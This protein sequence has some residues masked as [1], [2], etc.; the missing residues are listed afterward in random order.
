MKPHIRRK[1]AGGYVSLIAV[2]TMSLFMLSLMLFA[3]K[4][5]ISAQGIQG[6]IQSQTDYREKEETILRS[7]VAIAPNRAIRAMQSGSD[8]SSATRDPLRWQNIFSEA[9]DQSNARQSVSPQLL[10][11]MNI[12]ESFSA[13]SGDSSLG[14]LSRIFLPTAGNTGF[15]SSALNR[16]LGT[17]FPPSLNSTIG[18]SNDDIYPIIANQK[19]YGSL[20]SGKVGLSTTTY[21]KFNLLTY[22]QINFGYSKPGDPFVAKRNAWAFTMDLADHDTSVTKLARFKRQFVVSIYEIPS[23]LPISASSFMALGSYANGSAWQNVTI[24]GNIFAGRAIVEG[25]TSLPGLATRRGSEMSAGSTVGGKN[26]TGNPFTPGIRENYRLTEGNFFPFSMAS[27]S[28]KAAFVAINRGPDYFDRYAHTTESLTI[29]PTTWN[30]YSVGALQCAM[31]LDITKCVSTSD[32]TPTEMKFSYL[33]NG[34]RQTLTMPLNAGVA[35]NLPVGYILSGAENSSATFATP[36]DVAYGANGSFYY[37]NSVSGTIRFDNATFGDPIVGT[38]KN[39]YYKPIYPFGIKNLPNGKICVAVYPERFANFMA[40]LGADNLGINNSLAVNVDYVTGS[41]LTKPLIPCTENDYGVIL[42]ECGN[43]TSFTTG[44]SLVTNLRLHI[45][46]D[47]NIVTATPPAGYTPPGGKPFYP[48]A[49]LFAP[50]KR[51]GVNFDPFGVQ[52]TGQIGSVASENATTPVR[53]LDAKGVSGSAMGATTIS[54]NLSPITHPA[55]LPPITMMN[56]LIVVDE[57]RKEYY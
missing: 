40:H 53:P 3:Y 41:N 11:S 51:Y 43:L 54:I 25:S 57:K 36:V 19:Q 56:W 24:N 12:P 45:G 52:H 17:G 10:A 6:D 27:E 38:V 18:L 23:Q 33:K 50:E 35:S 4:R 13:N 9:I 30:T 7:I 8:T 5:A 20:A 21:K 42:Q 22:P 31:R 44:F 39:G 1:E 16:D 32:R 47:F 46:G 49:S 14:I 55:E 2:F 48:P 28:G 15:V 26:Y 29:S 37:K 34:T